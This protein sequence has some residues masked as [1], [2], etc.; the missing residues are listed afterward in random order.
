MPS[1]WTDDGTAFVAQREDG[2]CYCQV[3]NHHSRVTSRDDG[4]GTRYSASPTTT[5]TD[6][7]CT[8]AYGEGAARWRERS[9]MLPP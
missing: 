5:V 6:R 9:A 3:G 7:D 4:V 2:D 1:S 8:D